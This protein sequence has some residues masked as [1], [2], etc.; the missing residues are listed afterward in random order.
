MVLILDKI[1]TE[2]AR[3]VGD[4]NK[5]RLSE[6]KRYVE[7]TVT[8]LTMMLRKGSVFQTVTLSVADNEATLPIGVCAVLKVYTPGGQFF[9]VVDNTEYRRRE[10]G[11]SNLATAQVFEDVPYWKIKLLNFA[12]S[13]DSLTV[14]YLLTTTNPGIL[15]DYYFELLATGAEYK[16][17]LRRSPRE[18]AQDVNSEFKLLKNQFNENQSYNDG[19]VLRMK[20]LHEINLSDPNNGFLSNQN[21]D[22]LA[23]GGLF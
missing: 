7:S 13:V 5:E 21:N 14:D 15:P 19:R 6:I 17:H 20:S 4:H 11:T 1:V 18:K 8:E 22:Y 2:V 10:A 16:Y 3:R 12:D 23:S 9:E